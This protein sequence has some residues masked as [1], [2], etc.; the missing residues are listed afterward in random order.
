MG[1]EILMVFFLSFFKCVH[2]KY[3][4]KKTSTVKQ[5]KLTGDQILKMHVK[6]QAIKVR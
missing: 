1:W 5:V 2:F 4:I 6:E 3:L